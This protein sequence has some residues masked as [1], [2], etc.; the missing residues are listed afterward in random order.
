MTLNSIIEKTN[1][2]CTNWLFLN[3]I[4]NLDDRHLQSG[5]FQT[6]IAAWF[7]VFIFSPFNRIPMMN[8]L[9]LI[10]TKIVHDKNQSTTTKFVAFYFVFVLVVFFFCSLRFSFRASSLVLHSDCSI[11]FLCDRLCLNW[12]NCA[13]IL[14]RLYNNY[15]H[16]MYGLFIEFDIRIDNMRTVQTLCQSLKVKCTKN[17]IKSNRIRR[18]LVSKCELNWIVVFASYFYADCQTNE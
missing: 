18:L 16:A 1:E 5:I 7:L 12:L 11:V 15:A 2:Q 14:P 3:G 10:Y 8:L 13:M 6:L 4:E 9:L 17:Q